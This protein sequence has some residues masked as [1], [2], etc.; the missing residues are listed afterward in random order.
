MPSYKVHGAGPNDPG[1]TIYATHP[2]A[3]GTVIVFAHKDGHQSKI[4]VALW[5][6]LHDGTAVPITTG[7]V[8]NGT[9]NRNVFVQHPSGRCS[10]FDSAW[11][12]ALLAAKEMAQY[13]P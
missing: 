10:N 2:A 5:G 7:G 9:S 1:D 12:N 6:V 4:E 11:D 8:W 3:P 13:E